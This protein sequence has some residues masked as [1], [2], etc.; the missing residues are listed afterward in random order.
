[1]RESADKEGRVEIECQHAGY[2]LDAEGLRRLR[3]LPAHLSA[4][5]AI[6]DVVG[7]ELVLPDDMGMERAVVG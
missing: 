7:G 6:L 3:E 4:M 1:M 2:L 5:E